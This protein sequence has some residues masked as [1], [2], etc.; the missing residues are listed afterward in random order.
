MFFFKARAPSARQAQVAR[1]KE[2][3]EVPFRFVKMDT[4][5]AAEHQRL[6]HES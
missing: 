1:A 2:E 3:H 6:I 5:V 4:D